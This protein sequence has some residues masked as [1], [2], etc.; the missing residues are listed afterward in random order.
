MYKYPDF[1]KNRA[2]QLSMIWCC[3]RWWQFYGAS[4]HQRSRKF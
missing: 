2:H 3:R 4:R 1:S